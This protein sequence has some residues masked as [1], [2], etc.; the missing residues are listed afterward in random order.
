VL[1]EL[2]RQLEMV[3]SARVEQQT[4]TRTT[5]S[6][7]SYEAALQDKNKIEAEVARLR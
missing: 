1:G 5:V 2:G 3:K 6:L 7:A 4:A